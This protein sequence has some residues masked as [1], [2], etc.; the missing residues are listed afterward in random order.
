VTATS[1]VYDVSGLPTGGGWPFAWWCRGFRCGGKYVPV[2]DLEHCRACVPPMAE[3]LASITERHL[4]ASR[5]L[6]E[7]GVA[8]LDPERLWHADLAR[9]ALVLLHRLQ[10]HV[11]DEDD[12]DTA[13]ERPAAP[14]TAGRERSR[15]QT[16][17]LIQETVAT[18]Y[19][20]SVDELRGP[21][22]DRAIVLPRQV[23]MFLIREATASSLE[24]ICRAFGGRDHTTVW[25]ACQRIGRLG[26]EGAPVRGDLAQIRDR[27]VRMLGEGALL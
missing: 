8:V 9:D 13:Q 22:R 23:A 6:G 4:A 2:D 10:P 1:T 12:R 27:L 5:A 24:A 18:F 7:A 21:R 15:R 16:V 20:L 19:G 11:L 17:A 14:T 26:R 3:L 25:H